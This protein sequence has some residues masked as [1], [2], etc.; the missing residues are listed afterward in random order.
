MY[1]HVTQYVHIY[2]HVHVYPLALLHNICVCTLK[3]C[4]TIHMCVHI[5]MVCSVHNPMRHF[6]WAVRQEH[7]AMGSPL[8]AGLAGMKC[9]HY[10]PWKHQE[11]QLPRQQTIHRPRCSEVT[12]CMYMYMYVRRFRMRFSQ[13]QASSA[14]LGWLGVWALHIVHVQHRW[15]YVHV[16]LFLFNTSHVRTYVIMYHII[17]SL[18]HQTAH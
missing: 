15:L 10:T 13:Y 18:P 7:R 16:H 12:Q 6:L 2:V 11:P 17:F 5:G 9:G 4:H 14:Q 3:H 8:C 1:L